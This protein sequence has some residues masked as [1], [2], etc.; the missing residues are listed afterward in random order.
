MLHARDLNDSVGESAVHDTS[1]KVRTPNFVFVYG[2][3]FA[4]LYE[5]CRGMI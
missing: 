1:A 4:I 5:F 3:F 2:F